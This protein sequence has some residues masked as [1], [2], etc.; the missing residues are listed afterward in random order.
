MIQVPFDEINVGQEYFIEFRFPS[1]DYEQLKT[2][3]SDLNQLQG[4]NKVNRKFFGR[5]I[6]MN[7][8]FTEM[9]MQSYP[10]GTYQLLWDLVPGR[11]KNT[12][13]EAFY[14]FQERNMFLPFREDII[15]YRPARRSMIESNNMD[16]LRVINNV[17]GREI[18]STVEVDENTEA[19][20]DGF[21]GI[22]PLHELKIGNFYIIDVI[23]GNEEFINAKKNAIRVKK[24][25]VE[26]KEELLRSNPTYA[27]SGSIIAMYVGALD[28]HG[29]EVTP[30]SRNIIHKYKFCAI[31]NTSEIM[32]NFNKRIKPHGVYGFSSTDK[33][34]SG[35][36]DR[37]NNDCIL[38][39]PMDFTVRNINL[40]ETSIRTALLE[41]EMADNR[42]EAKS[43]KWGCIMSGGK[44]K[45][46]QKD[47][48]ATKKC[49]RHKN[50]R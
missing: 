39:S 41:Q 21:Y 30:G 48:N 31:H 26:K 34:I 38:L 2:Y 19:R 35:L 13:S 28:I 3:V 50:K 36:D 27:M 47:V 6:D 33:Y 11:L 9:E 8:D 46:K 22:I 5:C 24:M 25:K 49:K 23:R 15:Y 10:E 20:D 32:E 29:N 17:T 44:R 12:D 37:I 45:T 7:N 4:R 1:Q 18:P 14:M 43:R 40:Y 16:I 42:R